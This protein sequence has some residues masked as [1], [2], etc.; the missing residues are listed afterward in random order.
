MQIYGAARRAEGLARRRSEAAQKAWRTRRRRARPTPTMRRWLEWLGRPENVIVQW[1]TTGRGS[2]FHFGAYPEN[3]PPQR[4]G[5]RFT[6]RTFLALE[7]RKWVEPFLTT[8]ERYSGS[9]FSL[10]GETR[11]YSRKRFWRLTDKGRRA[12]G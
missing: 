8:P 6:R 12:L 1:T 4:S 7:S 3:T 10:D 11:Y 5:L 2:S 9:S